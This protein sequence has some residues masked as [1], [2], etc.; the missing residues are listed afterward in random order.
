MDFMHLT[1]AEILLA[2]LG[3]CIL[4]MARKY[5][6][7]LLQQ[8]SKMNVTLTEIKT[9]VSEHVH[10]IEDIKQDLDSLGKK[11]RKIQRNSKKERK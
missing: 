8:F 7:D 1:L 11:I 5:L 3:S 2:I 4:W 9:T 10:Q 6:T